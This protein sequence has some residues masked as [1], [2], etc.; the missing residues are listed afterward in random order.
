MT[1]ENYFMINLHERMLLTSGG[2]GG[3]GGGGGAE[4]ATSWSPVGRRI[5]LSHRGKNSY[6]EIFASLGNIWLRSYFGLLLKER[7]LSLWVHF[8]SAIIAPMFQRVRQTTID[9]PYIQSTLVISN[10]KWLSEILRDIR[11]S[12]YQICRIE[13]K[14]NR[15]T[16]FNKCIRNWTL[17]VR[18][19]LKILWK[20]GEIA[21]SLLFHNIFYL[22]L[23]FRV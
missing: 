9:F 15:T 7:I 11:T 4:P 17:E 21:I 20:R 22:L 5:Q 2:G 12:T 14:I 8:F 13:E 19:I 6:L 23:D 10:S 18:D 16:T 1:V 3:G